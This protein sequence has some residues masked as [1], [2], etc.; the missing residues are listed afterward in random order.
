MSIRF[1]LAR[2]YG[3]FLAMILVV[4]G[5]LSYA[6]HTRGHYDDLDRALL[7]TADHHAAE[8]A[9]TPAAL[10]LAEDGVGFDIALRLYD[11]QGRLLES[12][13]QSNQLPPVDPRTIL[14]QPSAPAYGRL[15]GWVPLL[16]PPAVV[17]AG[18]GFGVVADAAERWRVIVVP[19]QD[20]RRSVGLVAA[21]AP[22]ERLDH[23]MRRFQLILL[24]LGAISIVVASLGSWA[25]ARKVLQPIAQMIATAGGIAHS[26]DFSQRIPP[27]RVNDELHQ[28]ADTFNQMLASLEV[29]Y[30]SQQRFV[31][32]ASHELRAPLTAIQGNLELL[33][34]RR[35]LPAADREEAIAEAEREAQRLSRLVA[36]L[37]ALARADAGIGLRQEVVDLDSLVLE[38]FRSV[39]QRATGHT[40]ALDPFEPVSVSGDADRLQQLVVILIDNALKYTPAGGQVQVGLAQTDA[41]ARITVTDTGIGIAAADLPQVFERFYRADPARS[42]DPGGTGLGLPIARWIA[43]QHGGTITIQSQPQHGTTVE[44][45]LPQRP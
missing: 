5:L 37:L 33:R 44:V 31:A 9:R 29:A 18:S 40:L 22:L 32:D 1:R 39:R 38:V 25:L 21:F 24:G 30:R 17:P 3:A 15:V 10:H 43:E 4:F 7:T 13:P 27:G 26:R 8:A 16:A 42:R 20:G 36:D 41:A 28:L 35:D 45:F 14:A 12:S 6:W 2:W 23:A 19:I 11:A 34:R